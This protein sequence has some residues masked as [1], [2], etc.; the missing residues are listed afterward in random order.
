MKS[1]EAAKIAILKCLRFGDRLSPEQL[2]K[3]L[4]ISYR[5]V[6]EICRDLWTEGTLHRSE[7]SRNVRGRNVKYWRI[8][9]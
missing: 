4:D 6:S 1:L 9:L 2:H 7:P 8:D 3:R 5:R